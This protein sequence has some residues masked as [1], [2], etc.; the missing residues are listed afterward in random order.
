MVMKSRNVTFSDLVAVDE[1]CTYTPDPDNPTT[2]TKFVQDVCI[3]NTG[4]PYMFASK[5]EKSMADQFKKTATKGR[6]AMNEVCDALIMAPVRYISN[7]TTSL[8]NT[9]VHLFDDGN[10][11]T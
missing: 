9:V 6:D 7:V 3:H 1:T 11:N 2:K 8:T 4:I 10:N 5:V